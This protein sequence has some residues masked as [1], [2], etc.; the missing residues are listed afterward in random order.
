VRI[1]FSNSLLVTLTEAEGEKL[2]IFIDRVMGKEHLIN[3]IQKLLFDRHFYARFL[4]THRFDVDKAVQMLRNYLD[5]RRKHNIDTILVSG[6]L[7]LKDFEF[8]QFEKIK[9][10]FPHGFHNTDKQGRPILILQVGQIKF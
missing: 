7:T 10:L 6:R 3:E 9:E 4:K 5:W 8:N 2:Q 1:Y